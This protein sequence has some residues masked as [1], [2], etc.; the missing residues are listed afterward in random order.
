LETTLQFEF[1]KSYGARSPLRKHARPDKEK[2]RG[3]PGQ[4]GAIRNNVS[5]IRAT[6]VLQAASRS[7]SNRKSC[8]ARSPLRKH[9]RPDKPN[10]GTLYSISEYAMQ[11]M[12]QATSRSFSNRKSSDARSPLRKYARPEK[13]NAGVIHSISGCITCEYEEPIFDKKVLE[14]HTF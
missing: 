14:H 5:K 12:L 7:F 2:R 10:V 9:A 4:S 3:N 6:R 8:D 13:P 1:R 11:R